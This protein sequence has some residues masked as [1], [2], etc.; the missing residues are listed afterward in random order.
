MIDTLHF[1]RSESSLTQLA[2]LPEDL[3]NLIQ[4]CDAGDPW[5][6]DDEAFIQIAR[7]DREPPGQGNI[8][9]G[10]I[11]EAM[12]E[13]PYALEVPN[14]EKRE[15]LGVEEFAR[16]VREATEAFFD[17]VVPGRATSDR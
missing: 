5:S 13:V 6:V 12:P 14:D 2:D 15:E 1:A 4:L 3:F 9:L 11:V 16:Q 10:S 7:T 8:D 17:G